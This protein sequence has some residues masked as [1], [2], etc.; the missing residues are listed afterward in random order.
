MA[1]FIDSVVRVLFFRFDTVVEDILESEVHQS[2]V[3]SHVSV[4]ARAVDQLLFRVFCA[5]ASGNGVNRFHISGGRE[6]PAGT[7][8]TLIFHAG[9]DSLVLPVDGLGVGRNGGDFVG[10]SVRGLNIQTEMSAGELV[11]SE[12]HELVLRHMV[13]LV[14]LVVFLDFFEVVGEHL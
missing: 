14:E 4:L 9:N 5:F 8:C 12:I 11:L 1:A 3:A 2:T 7:T 10:G 6:G 13:V